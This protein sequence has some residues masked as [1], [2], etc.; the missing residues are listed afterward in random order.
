MNIFKCS[1]QGNNFHIY[2]KTGILFLTF[3]GFILLKSPNK[4]NPTS[5][6]PSPWSAVYHMCIGMCIMHAFIHV[7]VCSSKHICKLLKKKWKP[8]NKR[9]EFGQ[10]APM[11]S[12]L[13]GEKKVFPYIQSRSLLFQFMPLVSLCATMRHCHLA[14]TGKSSSPCPS[15]WPY[16]EPTPLC[17]CL[18]YNYESGCP[19]VD[20]QVWTNQCWVEKDNGFPNWLAVL[21]L[22][23]LR[24]LLG[25]LAG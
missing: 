21:L 13:Q 11:L 23:E 10:S 4:F 24:T 5:T 19:N 12:G 20:V 7:Y 18:S 25:F 2:V 1:H 3:S 22:V 16:V 17:H 6:V 14:L 8:L 9:F 15:W